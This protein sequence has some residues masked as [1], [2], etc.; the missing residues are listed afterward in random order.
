MRLLLYVEGNTEKSLPGFFSRWLQPRLHNSV[1][2]KPV[3]FRGAGKYRREFAERAR[4][5]LQSPHV[6]GVVGV[7]DFYGSGLPYP[8]GSIEDKYI[9]AKEHLERQV[10]EPGFRQHFAV[11]ETEAWLFS[12]PSIFRQEIRR[13]LPKIIQPESVNSVRPPSFVLKDLYRTKL[14]RTYGKSIEG[15]SLFG[16]LSP[17][18]AYE[19]CPHLKLLLDDVLALATRSQ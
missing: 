9:W 8:Q 3:N 11:H 6:I 15:S 13:A 18:T 1:Q 4:R 17:E 12:E 2:I 7:L 19:R 5:D 14:S 10:G 16:K